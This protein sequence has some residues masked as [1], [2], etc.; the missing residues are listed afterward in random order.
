MKHFKSLGE[1][2]PKNASLL[3][4]AIAC[5]PTRLLKVSFALFFSQPILLKVG[6][7]KILTENTEQRRV[8]QKERLL[9]TPALGAQLLNPEAPPRHPDSREHAQRCVKC[10]LREACL[11]QLP[12]VNSVQ[13]HV[14]CEMARS[15]LLECEY[16]AGSTACLCV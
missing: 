14:M 4:R 5:P 2:L 12:S 15:E 13:L 7:W 9:H 3:Q 1:R 16:E 6:E 10:L 11:S 8:H